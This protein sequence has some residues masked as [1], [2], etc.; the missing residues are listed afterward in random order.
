MLLFSWYK[1]LC[2]FL[3]FD[4]IKQLTFVKEILQTFF[5]FYFFIVLFIAGEKKTCF[6]ENIFIGD[7]NK[8]K[9]TPGICL[10]IIILFYLFIYYFLR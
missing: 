1:K 4:I 3:I 8:K 7:R 6:V 9:Q 10:N 2:Q 5:L